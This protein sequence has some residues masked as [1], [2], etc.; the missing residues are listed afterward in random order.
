MN[1]DRINGENKVL[2]LRGKE[3]LFFFSSS[4][5]KIRYSFQAYYAYL[6]ICIVNCVVDSAWVWRL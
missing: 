4:R 5:P 2:F 6:T 1:N 3:E